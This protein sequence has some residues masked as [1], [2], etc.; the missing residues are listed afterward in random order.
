MIRRIQ[1]WKTITSKPFVI[2]LDVPDDRDDEEY[3]EEFLEST[4]SD[5]VNQYGDWTFE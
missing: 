3:I 5:L 1:F 4:L 2:E